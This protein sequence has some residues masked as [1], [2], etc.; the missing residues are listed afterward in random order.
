M[1]LRDCDLVLKGGVASGLVYG[2]LIGGLSQS[3]RFRGL[4]GASAGAIAAA[5]AAAGE[6]ARQSGDPHGFDRLKT[7]CEALPHL[8]PSL[9]Q[10]AK[11][12][13]ALMK[14]VIF[15]APG[16]FKPRWGRALA[17]LYAS[18]LTGLICGA[19]TLALFDA[20]FGLTVGDPRAWPGIAVAA[21]FG[22]LL[23]LCAYVIHRVRLAASD[24]HF[25]ICSGLGEH[26]GQPAITDW[27]DQSLSDVAGCDRDRVL[28]FGDLRRT[29][30]DLRVVTTNITAGRIHML[31]EMDDDICFDPGVWAA[32]FP[33]SVMLHLKATQSDPAAS[34]WRM[35][36]T[37]DLPVLV[38]V[39]MSLGCPGLLA[40]VP[41]EAG[42]T[43]HYLS[44]GGL[45]LNFPHTV[46]DRA[47]KAHPTFGVDLESLSASDDL[48]RR[49]WTL[50]DEVDKPR[51]PDAIGGPFVFLWAMV[52]AMREAHTRTLISDPA[53]AA[54]IYRIGLTRAQG[55]MNLDMP[56]AQVRDLMAYGETAA[57]IITRDWSQT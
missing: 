5:L 36:A 2:S 53:C 14:A 31:P 57:R 55:G 50:A 3:W 11:P 52:C 30:I 12:F 41:I 49:V 17:S 18:I 28:T 22:A 1:A 10:L 4:A 45:A 26:A 47:D 51:A 21:L 38:A 19:G 27:L 34:L 46:F 48:D 39:R 15:L 44:D 32:L 33:L 13:R 42:R 7:R 43:R 8:L 29:G 54:R 6:Y 20:A 24:Y 25:G 16:S 35:P 56:P 37:D 9:F 40:Q 23:G